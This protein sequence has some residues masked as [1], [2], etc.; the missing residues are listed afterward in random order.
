MASVAALSANVESLTKMVS[1]LQQ[2]NQ[3]L[4]KHL[5]LQTASSNDDASLK[6]LTEEVKAMRAMLQTCEHPTIV[7]AMGA[8]HA[9]LANDPKGQSWSAIVKTAIKS[10]LQD[11]QYKAEVVLSQMPEKKSDTTD[12][13][14]LCSMID[15]TVRPTAVVPQ[16]L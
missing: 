2:D 15:V 13:K 11:E 5:L 7:G 16:I 14:D 6:G 4:C 3:E 12:V 8:A 10:V 1:S 9:Q